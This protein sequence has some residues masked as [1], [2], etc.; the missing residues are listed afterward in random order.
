MRDPIPFGGP[1]WCAALRDEV[2]ASSEYRNAAAKWG[3]GWNGNLLLA[4]E[5][6]AALPT[7]LYLFLAL[8][9]GRCGKVEFVPGPKHPES[10]FS[11]RAPFTLWRE[12]LERRTLAATAILTGKMK[13]EGDKLTLLK[14]AGANRALIHCVASVPTEFPPPR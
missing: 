7:P 12:I 3:H 4:F 2:N 8:A 10:G 9:E 11:L 6:D 14:H 5:A 13:V 1:A